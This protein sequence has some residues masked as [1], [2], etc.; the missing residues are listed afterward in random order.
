MVKALTQQY[1]IELN[2]INVL[3]DDYSSPENQQIVMMT[4]KTL[5]ELNTQFYKDNFVSWGGLDQLERLQEDGI[6]CLYELAR[7]LMEEHFAD[8]I[9]VEEVEQV[10]TMDNGATGT[11]Y[12]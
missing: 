12:I 4:Y 8:Y 1:Q 9:E 10:S 7:K 3:R 6:E 11:F 5:F 2:M